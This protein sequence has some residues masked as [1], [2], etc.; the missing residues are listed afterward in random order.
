MVKANASVDLTSCERQAAVAIESDAE[1]LDTVLEVLSA[2]AYSPVMQQVGRGRT[3]AEIG[4]G[5]S[6]ALVAA[7]VLRLSSCEVDGG[8]RA[9]REERPRVPVACR[10]TI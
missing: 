8:E 5:R 3:V 9:G 4:T 1:E 10:R 7:P 6:R 2:L